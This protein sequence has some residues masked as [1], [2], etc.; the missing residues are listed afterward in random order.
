MVHLARHSMSCLAY[1]PYARET[2]KEAS[3]AGFGL[4][5]IV[6]L[7]NISICLAWEDSFYTCYMQY[8]LL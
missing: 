3:L 1:L 6:D 2:K 5:F 7:E 8:R 4:D